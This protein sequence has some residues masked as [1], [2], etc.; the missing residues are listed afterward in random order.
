MDSALSEADELVDLCDE[1]VQEFVRAWIA[2]GLP[3]PEV[4]Y[5]LQDG[6]GRVCAQA[7]L[8]W[9]RR[10]VAAMLPEGGDHRAE[11]EKRG[12]TVL[13][14]TDLANHETELKSLLG[15]VTPMPTVA[16]ADDFL[17]AFDR[18]PRAQQRK[19]RDFTAKFKADPRSA[20]I[21][22]EKIHGSR[23]TRS[24]PCG[25]TSTIGRSCSTPNRATCTSCFG[26]TPTT[27]R[28]TWA[29]KRTFEINPRTGALQVI[30]VEEV[31]Q[32]IPAGTKDTARPGLLRSIGDDVLLSFGVPEILL[33]AVRAIGSP[34]E[35][36]ALGKHLPSEAAEALIWLAEGDSPEAVRD[37]WRVSV[38]QGTNRLRPLWAP[39]P[40]SQ[41]S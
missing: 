29:A 5:E 40:S 20:A 33:P 22:Y 37:T 39:N 12:W 30:S 35:L 26:S 11:F 10:K 9:P 7:E 13:D 36:I 19:V 16:I 25:S 6:K 21:N 2:R 1:R 23:T 3:V 15:G 17:D 34:E 14:A 32:A 8:A 18:I 38:Q 4:G 41:P 31:E 28:W 24:E 27:R